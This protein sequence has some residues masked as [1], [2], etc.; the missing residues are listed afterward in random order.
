LGN[1]LGVK[2]ERASRTFASS[3]RKTWEE[4]SALQLANTWVSKEWNLNCDWE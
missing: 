2:D 3:Y 1:S 4:S